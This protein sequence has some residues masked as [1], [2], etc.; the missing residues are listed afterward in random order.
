MKASPR[1]AWNILTA[2]ENGS[3]GSPVWFAR[4]EQCVYARRSSRA[5]R[6]RWHE[7][8]IKPSGNLDLSFGSHF[9]IRSPESST[10]VAS[11]SGAGFVSNKAA[12]ADGD[13]SSRGGPF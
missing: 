6:F 1:L 8:I 4:V 7:T 13:H 12:G 11:A 10:L 2:M 5:G 3:L 9:G